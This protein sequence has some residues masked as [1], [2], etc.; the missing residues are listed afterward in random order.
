[1]LASLF[2]ATVTVTIAP[3]RRPRLLACVTVAERSPRYR[4][5]QYLR[6]LT[7]DTEEDTQQMQYYQHLVN[8]ADRK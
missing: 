8:L 1:V 2:L 7:S 5:V 3:S 6:S 4:P